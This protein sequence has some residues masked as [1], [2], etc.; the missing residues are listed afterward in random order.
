[1]LNAVAASGG[2]LIDELTAYGRFAWGLRD[3]LSQRTTPEQAR[4]MVRQRLAE[5]ELNFLRMLERGVY[6]HPGS[7]YLPLLK[8]AG[9]E[10]GDLR[11]LVRARGLEGTLRALR[12]AG[13]YVSFEEFKG[14]TPMVRNGAV[15][16]VQPRDFDNPFLGAAYYSE[17]GGTSGAGTRVTIELDHLAATAVHRL[18]GYE[19]HGVLHAPLA[20]WRGGFPD[21]SGIANVLQGARI[22][23]TPHAWF[24]PL[25][26]RASQPDFKH[27]LATRLLVVLGRTYG[28]PIPWPRAV[29]VEQADVVARWAAVAVRR[30]GRCLIRAHVSLALRV[31]LAARQ[32]GQDLRGVTFI[33]GGEPPTPAKV[34]EIVRSGA[35]WV[36]WYAFTEAGIVG[37]GCAR[38]IGYNDLHLCTDGLALIQYPQAVAGTDATVPGFCFT[39]LLPTAP[40]LLLNVQSDDY[41]IVETRQCGCPLEHDGFTTHVRDVRSYS[42]LTGEGVTLVG[43]DMLRILDEV[44][45]ARFGG[46]A[47]DYQLVEEED[48]TGFT[49]LVLA[50]NPRLDIADEAEIVPTVL[51]VLTQS[52]GAAALASAAWREAGTLRIARRAPVWTDRGKL[53]PLHLTAR[54]SRSTRHLP[55]QSAPEAASRSVE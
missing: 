2:A 51:D 33:S 10:L 11:N 21:G 35:H 50:V 20:L 54:T 43:S 24:S 39:S 18:L 15:F 30:H 42:K 29:G 52:S 13:V 26:Q 5:R 25:S 46:S 1:M 45:P 27:R 23:N 19:A 16:V 28:A 38:P 14:R 32:A 4:A 37:M 34:R 3:F 8:L 44:L 31:C 36:P 53:M 17:S 9:C 55:A 49:R 6:G 41:G 22:G 12:E 48:D 7:P 47:L 40:K